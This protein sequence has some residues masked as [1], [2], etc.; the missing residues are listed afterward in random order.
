MR[1]QPPKSLA[2]T[3]TAM[4]STAGLSGS[5]LGPLK[6]Q[7]VDEKGSVV[8]LQP[9]RAPG[10]KV[11]TLMMDL[12][13]GEADETWH[14]AKDSPGFK[15]CLKNCAYYVT[16]SPTGRVWTT[17]NAP[18]LPESTTCTFGV[19]GLLRLQ[20]GSVL[21]LVTRAKRV[22]A[23]SCCCTSTVSPQPAPSAA[24]SDVS[25]ELPPLA[26]FT[27]QVTS[28]PDAIYHVEDTQ[29]ITHEAVKSTVGDLRYALPAC[30]QA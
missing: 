14:V 5:W 3:I 6:T 27:W 24:Q 17:M 29:L 9:K 2:R 21:A 25:T 13:T 23:W 19:L 11:P 12:K 26:P 15:T 10:T 4:A 8:M 28:T 20:A 16:H 7:I 1:H 18:A 30:A 22:C